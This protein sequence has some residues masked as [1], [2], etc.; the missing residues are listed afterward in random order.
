MTNTIYV[1]SFAN[2]FDCNADVYVVFLRLLGTK[3]DVKRS[4]KNNYLR[5][6]I[7]KY[8]HSPTN[9]PILDPRGS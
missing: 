8:L 1:D 7:A 6:V 4:N 9:E 5:D 2:M 3:N